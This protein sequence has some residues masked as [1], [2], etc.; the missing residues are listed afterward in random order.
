MKIIKILFPASMIIGIYIA[1]QYGIASLDDASFSRYIH[2]IL[3]PNQ[4]VEQMENYI[5]REATKRGLI[6]GEDAIQVS[7]TE[8]KPGA[9]I[10]NTI[11]L[12]T[13]TCRAT[14][15]YQSTIFFS[16]K[17]STTI[18]KT[19]NLPVKSEVINSRYK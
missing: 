18:T 19:K 6:M 11:Q 8:P 13:T 2:S 12:Y 16:L 10:G 1:A 17:K 14:V 5:F 7:L 3:G 15:S 9:V 4:T